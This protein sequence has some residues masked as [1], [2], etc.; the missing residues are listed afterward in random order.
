MSNKVKRS[1]RIELNNIDNIAQIILGYIT[2][3]AGKLW[4]KASYLVK[5]EQAKANKFDLYNKLNL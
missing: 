4:N 5:N 2:Y 1:L 3:H